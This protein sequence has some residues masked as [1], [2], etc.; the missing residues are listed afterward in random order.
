VLRGERISKHF[1]GI[2]A[3]TNVDFHVE[4]GEVLGLIGPNGSGKSTLF[5]VITKLLH[6]DGGNLFFK[7]KE[8]THMKTHEICKLGIARTFQEVRTFKE[9]TALENVLAGVYFQYRGLAVGKTNQIKEA[10][11]L[12]DSVNLSAKQN[13]L[14]K[15][16]SLVDQRKL[17]I[18]RALSLRPSL[19]L[20]DEVL[21]GLIPGEVEQALEMIRGIKEALA[22]TI[23]I[24]EHN[25]KA[26]T[27]LCTRIIVLNYGEKITEGSPSEVVKNP[28]VIQAYLGEKV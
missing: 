27:K 1:G 28:S 3:L 6:P 9:M 13:A 10:Q 2:S 25:I 7:G 21:A 19:L 14:A 12:L 24:I 26:L 20:L 4:E 8:I 16:L 11:D 5:N 22:L 17:E 18:A 23:F 15:D